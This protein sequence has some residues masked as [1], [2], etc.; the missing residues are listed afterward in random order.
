MTLAFEHLTSLLL[1]KDNSERTYPLG[2]SGKG[3]LANLLLAA[4]GL[5]FVLVDILQN[6]HSQSSNL[7]NHAS[8]S[9]FGDI[10]GCQRKV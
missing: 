7:I 9:L 2:G 4:N 3:G 1:P 5:L 10:Y 8:T 6:G